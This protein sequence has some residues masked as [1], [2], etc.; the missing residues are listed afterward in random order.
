MPV[1]T[2]RVQLTNTVD[3]VYLPAMI[4]ANVNATLSA[5]KAGRIVELLADRG[6]AITKGQQLL[7]IVADTTPS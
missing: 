1:T 4:N 6:D 2:R 3:I 5:E 7:Q